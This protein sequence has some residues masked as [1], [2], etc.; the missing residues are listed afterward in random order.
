MSE[1]LQA[2]LDGV[3]QLQADTLVGTFEERCVATRELELG[4]T[5][6]ILLNGRT[7]D[8]L[9]STTW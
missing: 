8:P 9:K 2:A 5:S 4:A 1:N 3:A 7:A 6:T